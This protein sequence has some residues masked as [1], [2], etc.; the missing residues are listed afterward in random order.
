LEILKHFG[1]H[2]MRFRSLAEKGGERQSRGF[3]RL[4]EGLPMVHSSLKTYH[5]D[6]L[7]EE[8]KLVEESR[9]ASVP[10]PK[11]MT[12]AWTAHAGHYAQLTH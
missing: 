2:L 4:V 9:I 5:T 8:S 3:G 11:K 1:N 12:S 7:E 6:R 10:T